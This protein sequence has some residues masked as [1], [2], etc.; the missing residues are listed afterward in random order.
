MNEADEQWACLCCFNP[1]VAKSV[2]GCP[3]TSSQLE[4]SL[5][6]HSYMQCLQI[7]VDTMDAVTE[8]HH[9]FVRRPAGETSFLLSEFWLHFVKQAEASL[10]A[11]AVKLPAR[12][13]D[14]SRSSRV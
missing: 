5:L 1:A 4:Y 2:I 6:A 8:A 12:D 14:Q 13:A 10:Q 11:H 7:L 9:T 3:L